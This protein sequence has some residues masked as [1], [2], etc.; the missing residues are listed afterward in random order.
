MRAKKPD[1]D[2]LVMMNRLTEAMADG[3]QSKPVGRILRATGG[4][5]GIAGLAAFS[6]L[7]D[8]ITVLAHGGPL[9]AEVIRVGVEEVTAVPEGVADGVA[10]DDRVILQGAPRFCPDDSWIG[11][12]IDPDGAALDGRP[13]LH[14]LVPRDLRQ[15]PPPA[16]ARRAM[17]ARLRT[18][19]MVFDTLLPIVQGQRLGLF[20]GSGVGKS[21]LL[22]GLARSIAADVIVIG[23]VGERGREVR[24]FIEEVLGP[25]GMARAVVVAATS[26]AAPQQRRR[27]AWA[28]TTVAEYFRDQG[29]QVL[30]MLDSVTRFA[31]AHRE[32]ASAAGEAAAL[33]GYPASTGPTIAALCERAGPGMG[34]QGDITAIYSVLVQG[35][36]MEEPVADMLRGTL[37]GHVI[38]D[39]A[40]AESGRFPAVDVLRSVSRSLPAAASL[41]ENAL[42]AEARSHMGQYDRAALMI[43]AGLYVGGSDPIV[44]AAIA[45]RPGLENLLAQ[46]NLPSNAA[47]FA[48]LRQVLTPLRVVGR[49]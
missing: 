10:V 18:G 5:L 45:A 13:L 22:G 40:I 14:G 6:R 28:A 11:R 20:A 33:R 19:Y 7:G 12:V 8:R 27:C 38:L 29:R 25:Q 16:A 9:Q 3:P 21:T 35:S 1:H 41:P 17:G 46:S 34:Q 2:Q 47:A 32:L 37:D 26:D 31:E 24:H 44:D 39:R 42:I 48:A 4:T 36:D 15:S 49:G 43:R 30:L 23:L